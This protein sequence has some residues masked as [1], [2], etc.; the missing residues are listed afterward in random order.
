MNKYKVGQGVYIKANK[1][2]HGYTIGSKVIIRS[3]AGPES[4]VGPGGWYFNDDE[5]RSLTLPIN[6]KIL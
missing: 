2:G 5:I 3:L 4:Y 6:I 1:Y